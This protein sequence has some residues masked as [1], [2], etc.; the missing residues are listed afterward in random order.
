[1]SW[2][3]FGKSQAAQNAEE[4]QLRQMQLL[5]LEMMQDLYA[6]MVESCHR[7]CIA[8]KYS[9]GELAKGE[10]VCLDRCVAKFMETYQT[11]S[12]SISASAGD[13]SKGMAAAMQSSGM[14]GQTPQQQ[15]QQR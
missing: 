3:S 6:R 12:Q 11:I 9:D 10:S 7:K 15:Q 2:F 8:P 5:E 14:S 13:A 4:V 1:M